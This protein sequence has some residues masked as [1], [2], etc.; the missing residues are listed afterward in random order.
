MATLNTTVGK[1][2]YIITVNDQEI[3]VRQNDTP[4]AVVFAAADLTPVE[5][6]RG[7]PESTIRYSVNWKEAQQ[8]GLD[9][10]YAADSKGKPVERSGSGV[11]K[12]A[13]ALTAIENAAGNAANA[14]VLPS[15]TKEKAQ[16]TRAA[17]GLP[18]NQLQ[19]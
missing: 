13:E 8:K 18:G 12:I 6:N 19:R 7:T 16:K 15:D 11:D 10:I 3:A 9:A 5:M 17:L 4:N 1:T 2:A 14:H